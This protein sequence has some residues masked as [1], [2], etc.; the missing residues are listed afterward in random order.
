MR[1][2]VASPESTRVEKGPLVL[3]WV[4]GS[5]GLAERLFSGSSLVGFLPL[6]VEWAGFVSEPYRGSCFL[7]HVGMVS[8][9]QPRGY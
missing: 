5:A 3:G 7:E 8:L 2:S 9:S 4:L 1:Q 6:R